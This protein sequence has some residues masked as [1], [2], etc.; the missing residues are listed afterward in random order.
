MHV[1][2]TEALISCMVSVQLICAI[3]FAYAKNRFSHDVAQFFDKSC[4]FFI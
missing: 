2:K 3:G 4:V 1:A